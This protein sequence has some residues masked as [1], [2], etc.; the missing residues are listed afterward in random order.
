L[1]LIYKILLPPEWAEFQANGEFTG[2]PDDRDSGFIHLSSRAQVGATAVR[3]FGEKGPLVVIAVEADTLGETVRWEA[4]SD[5]DR[6]PHV[7]GTLPLSAAVAVHEVPDAALVDQA[8]PPP[9]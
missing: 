8:L 3:I 6:F 1:V 7:Y 5:G 4:S 9:P 2:S